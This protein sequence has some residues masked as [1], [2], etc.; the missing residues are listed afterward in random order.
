MAL[1]CPLLRSG[2]RVRIPSRRRR[3][4]PLTYPRSLL[5]PSSSSSAACTSRTTTTAPS[6]GEPATSPGILTA[7]P[8]RPEITPPG[9]VRRGTP[10]PG[11][12]LPS[13]AL[14]GAGAFSASASGGTRHAGGGPLLEAPHKRLRDFHARDPAGPDLPDAEGAVADPGQPVYGQAQVLAD[15]ADLAVLV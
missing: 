12:R 13:H 10:T 8:T 6:T 14:P 2:A 15:L 4:H 11:L 7:A 1:P 5:A 3:P 9:L